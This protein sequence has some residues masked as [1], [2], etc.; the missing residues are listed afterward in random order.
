MDNA[1]ITYLFTALF[2]IFVLAIFAWKCYSGIR[3]PQTRHV[4]L[5]L[6]GTLALYVITDAASVAYFLDPFDVTAYRVINFAF[7]V[8]Y[9]VT[10]YVWHLFVRNFVGGERNARP[11]RVEAIPLVLLLT[12]G[13]IGLQ[14]GTVASISDAG[15]YAR[16]PLFSLFS[17]L[18]LF[19]Y[20]ETL[21]EAVAVSLRQEHGR[22]SLLF[23]AVPITLL[24]LFGI[25]VNSFMMPVGVIFPLQPYCLLL[26]VILGY[27]FMA[28]KETV[29]LEAEHQRELQV[30]LEQA[31]EAGRRAEE[32]S[33]A[34][35]E[36]LHR[37]SHDMRTP[38]NGILGLLHI[39]RAHADDAALVAANR[40][41]AE[42][43]ARHLLSLID[44]VLQTSKLEE[45][46]LKLAH[47][48][49]DLIVLSREITDIVEDEAVE[50]GL[51]WEYEP[52]GD[53]VPFRWVYG[54]ELH[55]RQIFLNIYSNCI[56]YNRPGGKISTTIVGRE[57]AYGHAVYRWVIEDTGIGMSPEFVARIFDRFSQETP[58]ARST[59]GGT[60]LGM[61]ITKSLVELMGGTI[62][63]ESEKGV[64]S[65]FTVEIPFDVALGPDERPVAGVGDGDGG[66]LVG[67]ETGGE[68]RGIAGAR[69]LMAE[70]NDLNAEI[71]RTLLEDAGAQVTVVGD[72]KQAVD[73]VAGSPAG[74]FDVVLMDVMMPVMDG[75]AAARAIRAL[76]RPDAATIPILAMTANAFAEDREACLAAGMDDHLAKPLD[77]AA[78]IATVDACVHGAR[79]A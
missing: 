3:R 79:E 63:V 38:L 59:Y 77:M 54:S 45:G 5:G 11:R 69:I 16:G 65:R 57:V 49:V 23:K 34:K 68:N 39:S 70:D 56:K 4:C 24:P 50:A 37:M 61:S 27:F 47:E 76:E 67:G 6:I 46:S 48:P 36:F 20:V 60:G 9:V 22:A 40:E 32:A 7:Y 43:A 14:T 52:V 71:A 28:D 66:G 75:L 12:M 10:P 53:R 31:Q 73:A 44:D 13:A 19:Y 74:T 78:V 18:N 25:F 8:V 15:E 29:T 58:G 26:V 42:T 62:K 72:G 51:T 30:A 21:I 41:K 17:L 64:G 55:L 35:T 1:I 2:M 33:L